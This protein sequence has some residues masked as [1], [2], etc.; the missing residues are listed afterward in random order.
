MNVSLANR[1]IA[2]SLLLLAIFCSLFSQLPSVLDAGVDGPLKVMWVLPFAY[3][4]LTAPQAF[5]SNRLM[6]FYAFTF[7]L[8]LYSFA[9]QMATGQQYFTNDLY[10]IAISLVMTMTSYNYWLHHGT[11]SIMQLICVVMLGVSLLVSVELWR[12]FLSTSDIMSGE[13]AYGEKNS[14]GQ[15]F[16][17]TAFMVFG[18]FTP[19]NKTTYWGC[20]ALAAV[21]VVVMFM[22]RSRATLLSAAYIVAFFVFRSDNKRLKLWIVSLALLAVG[23]L[24]ISA[25]AYDIIVNGIILGGRDAT[26]MNDLSSN[27][28][29]LFAMALQLIPQHPWI[30]SGDYYV[31]CMPLNILTEYGVFGLAIVLTFCLYLFRSTRRSIHTDKICMSA[32]IIYMSFMVNAMLEARPPFGPGVKCFTLWMLYGF[33]LA[34]MEKAPRAAA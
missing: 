20:R 24:L 34:V 14:V 30:G 17:C 6:P 29:V 9:C 19:K 12:D 21:L 31:D 18:F 4:L 33:A 13:Y 10:N 28:L 7:V 23:Y 8:T 1:Y 27:R 16:L 11:R 26:D 3:M 2:T 5:L 32:Y 22:L 15:I 25:S